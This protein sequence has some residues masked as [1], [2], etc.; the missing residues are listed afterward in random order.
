[1]FYFDFCIFIKL[2]V[3]LN[4][5]N[6]ENSLAQITKL[7]EDDVQICVDSFAVHADKIIRTQ[8][9]LALGAKY[10]MEAEMDNRQ[11]CLKLCCKTNECDVFVFEEKKQG[12]CYLFHCGPP[13]DF[14]CKFTS[15][16]NYSSAVLT[17]LNIRSHTH[18][19]DQMRHSQ[20][21]HELKS[22][23]KMVERPL[24]YSYTPSSNVLVQAATEI[25]MVIKS[26]PT[27]LP[28]I[29]IG[30]S[31][32]QYECRS[33]HDCIAI[34]NVCD[35][36][37][38]CSDASDEASDLGCPTEKPTSPPVVAGPPRPPPPP[39][40]EPPGPAHDLAKY[41][42]HHKYPP[43][44]GNPELSKTWHQ[45]YPQQSVQYPVPQVP[46][47]GPGYM[48]AWDYRQ[49]YDQQ[50]NKD[51]FPLNPITGNKDNALM[52]HYPERQH[53]FNHKRPGMPDNPDETPYLDPERYDPYY[54]RPV[55]ET[56]QQPGPVPDLHKLQVTIAPAVPAVPEK[57][58]SAGGKNSG[59]SKNDKV[60]AEGISTK[61][62]VSIKKELETQKNVHIKEIKNSVDKNDNNVDMNVKKD[63]VAENKNAHLNKTNQ[64]LEKHEVRVHHYAEHLQQNH[65]RD[66]GNEILKPRGAVISLALGLTVTAVLVAVLTCRLRV[67]RK[68]GK[69]H[70]PFAHDADYLVNGMYL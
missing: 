2:I 57:E 10:I 22:L 31:R 36:I 27:T 8:D 7:S 9:S 70:G 6:S 45:M 49:M 48:N 23:R 26:I 30:C 17:N 63:S 11:D 15:H 51:G 46:N 61:E 42:L 19:E 68:R 33:S 40:P 28:P 69:R 34:Y 21:E 47:Y 44:Y 54:P 64:K 5:V 3:I 65:N 38:Q 53:I 14:K 25:P 1:M 59:Q 58:T 60:L 16:V 62:S 4:F 13:H 18:S 32:N 43:L 56:W 12:S 55:H 37:P 66:V 20:Q 67:L 35:G 50:F 41:P 39:P 24:E 29:K 52:P